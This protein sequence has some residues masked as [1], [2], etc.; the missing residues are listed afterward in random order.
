MNVI[1]WNKCGNSDMYWKKAM[2]EK[3]SKNI[4]TG[5]D[6]FWDDE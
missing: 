5:F 6:N 1:F 2:I 3:N 4:E